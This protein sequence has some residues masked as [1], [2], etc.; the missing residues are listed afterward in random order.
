MRASREHT[1]AAAC[2]W[3]RLH[4]RIGI[5]TLSSA[6]TATLFD[7]NGVL[8]DDEHVHLAA[9]REVLAE[10]GV[11]VSDADYAERYLGF[12]DRGAFDAILRDAGRAPTADEVAAL[13]AAKVPVYLRLATTE[14]R[15]FPGAAD[16]VRR[17]AE[18]GTVAIVSGALRHEIELA[19][20][21]MGVRDAVAFIVAAEDT[22]ACKPDPEG[23]LVAKARLA[24]EGASAVVIE[25]SIAGIR[26]ARAAGLRCVAVAHSYPENELAA[27]GA[28]AV[29]ATIADVEL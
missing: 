2:A 25:D 19:L 15:I 24:S 16:V 23:Y 22:K 12:D 5:R 9:F 26:A 3:W 4:E 10:L 21:K 27:A 17:A 20:G 8:V 6:V 14:L 13:V 7:F 18:R 28:D 29:Y 11:R 1:N